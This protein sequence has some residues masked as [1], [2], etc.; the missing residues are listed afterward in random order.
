AGGGIRAFHVTGVQ[1]CALPIWPLLELPLKEVTRDRVAAW[2]DSEASRRPTR[3]RLALSLLATFI[4]WCSD[5]PE[6]RDQVHA[7]AC[8]R[9]RSAKRR[10]GTWRGRWGRG[11]ECR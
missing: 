6:Y 3:T 9:M 5:R 1:T 4:N 2:L 10:V 8:V 11:D 7:D